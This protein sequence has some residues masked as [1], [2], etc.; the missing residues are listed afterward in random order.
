MDSFETTVNEESTETK[1]LIFNP[2]TGEFELV[3]RGSCDTPS[4]PINDEWDY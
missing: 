3:E 4:R 2:E 1:D